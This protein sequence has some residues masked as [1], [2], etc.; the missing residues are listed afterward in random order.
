MSE[1]LGERSEQAT[2]KR[3]QEAREEGNIAKSA[4]LASALKLL[5]VTMLVTMAAAAMLDAGKVIL[6]RSLDE[7][8]APGRE[9]LWEYTLEPWVTAGRVVA[10]L[11]L[12]AWLVSYLSYFVQLGWLFTTKAAMPSASRMNPL[13]GFKRLFGPSALVK[14]SMDV[15]KLSVVVIVATIVVI[16][17]LQEIATLPM[18]EPLQN[19]GRIGEM[20]FDL[21]VAVLIV[22]LI[23]GVTDFVYQKWKYQR[24]LRMTKQQVKEEMRQSEG[25]PDVKRRRFRMMQQL[26]MQRLGSTVPRADVVVTNPEHLSVAIAYTPGA[27]NAPK[28]IAKGADHVALRIRQIAIQNNIPVIE[29]KPLARAL[30]KD[31][32]VGQEIPETFY[33]AVAEILAYVYRLKGRSAA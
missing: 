33:K 7:I 27:S 30:Y 4:D 9:L 26:A 11:L 22:L 21:A 8:G 16:G 19:L 5:A 32:E 13:S 1:D 28:V 2:P 18:L 24:D 15:A 10:P 17:M 3:L 12:L 31:V 14:T 6:E 20:C 25:D 29:R 23:L